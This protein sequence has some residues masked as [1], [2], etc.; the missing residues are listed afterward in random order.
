MSQQAMMN[1]RMMGPRMINPNMGM[2]SMPS[3]QLPTQS[4]QQM[5]PIQAMTPQQ[6]P[7]QIPP[8]STSNNPL[9]PRGVPQN[10]VRRPASAGASGKPPQHFPGQQMMV[11]PGLQN[12]SNPTRAQIKVKTGLLDRV[13]YFDSKL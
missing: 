4:P 8:S 12:Q 9:N 7:G 1:S 10:M 13:F 2:T 11:P 6:I 5:A 3:Q